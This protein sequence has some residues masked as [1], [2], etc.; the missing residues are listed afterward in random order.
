MRKNPFAKEA[1]GRSEAETNDRDNINSAWGIKL[2]L[3]IA[4]WTGLVLSVTP[5]PTAP[6]VRTSNI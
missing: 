3:S 6:N 2:H 5:S 1:C 4:A